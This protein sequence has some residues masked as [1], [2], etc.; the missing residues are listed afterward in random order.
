MAA[1]QSTDEDILHLKSSSSSSLKLEDIPL[2]MSDTSIL[3]DTSTGVAR[4]LVPK[5]FRRVVFESLHNLSHPSIRATQ[6]LLTAR[7]VWPGIKADSRKWTRT[8]LQCQKSKVQRHTVTPLSTF[9]IPG[10]RFDRIHIDIVGPLPPS[11]NFSYLLTCIDRFTRWP[12]AFPM[13]DVTAETVAS[14][15]VS[16]WIARFGVPSTI[17]TDRGRQFES[18]LWEQLTR[19]LGTQR[20]RTT[21]YHTIAN[22]LVERLHRQLKAA[23]KTYPIPNRW[24]TTL[25]MV[26]LGMRTALKE[27]LD[28]TAAELVYGTTL[29][30]PGEFFTSSSEPADPSTYVSL[31]KSSMQQLQATS[32]RPSQRPPYVSPALSTCTH[33]FIR[34][35]ATRKPLQQP[36]SGPYKVLKREDK[37]FVVD[38]NGRHDTV[39]MDRL[40]AAH[41][42][43]DPGV[44]PT[45]ASNAQAVQTFPSGPPTSSPP[46]G[47]HSLAPQSG[48]SVPRST[49]SGR[50]VHWPRHLCDFVP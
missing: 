29:R 45:P 5:D 21:A 14:T 17:T 2:S 22:G 23:L 3:C 38:I 39:S 15:F 7:F 9:P 12:E 16:G 31:L 47:S 4:P 26:L 46:S 36:Y 25:P 37:Y 42:E 40:K 1:A 35:D 30:L 33:V 48:S 6:R 43:S 20:T 44:S 19:L 24:T 13:V 10:H 34:C 32:P 41:I 50:H 49:R 8:C 11:Q 27:D 18:S 28:C